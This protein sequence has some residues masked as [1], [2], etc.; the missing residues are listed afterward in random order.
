[1]PAWFP[2]PQHRFPAGRTALSCPLPSDADIPAPAWWPARPPARPRARPPA[3]LFLSLPSFFLQ[4]LLE[5]LVDSVEESQVVTQP[6][7]LITFDLKTMVKEDA[8]FDA[9]AP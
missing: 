1:M 3:H 9:S 5:P 4:A 6:H 8:A 2:W 7:K